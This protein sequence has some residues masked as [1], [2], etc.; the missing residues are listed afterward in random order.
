MVVAMPKLRKIGFPSGPAPVIIPFGARV[1]ATVKVKNTG[2]QTGHFHISGLIVPPGAGYDTSKAIATLGG[3][4]REL[5]GGEEYTFY[6][7][8]EPLMKSGTFSVAWRLSLYDNV[9]KKIVRTDDSGTHENVIIVEKSQ[10]QGR[11][12]SIGYEK[13]Y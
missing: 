7:G 12:V 10:A 2:Q 8:T 1:K 5:K 4:V 3:L 11:I 6:L 9:R 13:W